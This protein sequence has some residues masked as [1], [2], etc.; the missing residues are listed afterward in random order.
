[1]EK[2]HP[3]LLKILSERCHPW[4]PGQVSSNDLQ[5]CILWRQLRGPAWTDD[6]GVLLVAAC[7]A[8]ASLPAWLLYGLKSA[9]GAR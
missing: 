1:M 9:P 7:A 8:A 6:N 3:G 4:D 2:A 5:C